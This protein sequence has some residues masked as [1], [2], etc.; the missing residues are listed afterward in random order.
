MNAR[1]HEIDVGELLETA[2]WAGF[3]PSPLRSFLILSS[4]GSVFRRCVGAPAI[5]RAFNAERAAMGT[6]FGWGYFG[7]FIGSVVFGIV[8]DR[9]GRRWAPCWACLPQPAGAAH[10]S[11]H[12]STRSRCFGS[13]RVS[14]SAGWCRTRSRS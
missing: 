10:L 6:V 2:N 8:G 14:A 3:T 12:R 1:T 5:L 11:P 4:T 7:I 13:S 9:Y